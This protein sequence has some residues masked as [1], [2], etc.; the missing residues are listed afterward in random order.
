MTSV[1]DLPSLSAA[2]LHHTCDPHQFDFQTTAELEDLGELIGQMRAMEAVQFG[3]GMHHAGYNI[4]VQGPSGMGKR[5]MVRQLLARKTPT[6]PDPPEWCYLHNFKQ[7]HKPQALS[8]PP[9]RGADLRDQ[10]AKLV[11]YLRSAIP[12]LF[13]SDEYRAKAEA[14]QHAFSQREE[15]ALKALGDEAE[16]QKIFLLRTPSGFTFVPTRDGE[17]IPPDDFNKLPDDEKQRIGTAISG[18]QDKLGKILEMLP[19]WRKERAE[20][21]K[22]LNQDNTLLTVKHALDDIRTRFADVPAVLAHLDVVQQ[23]MVEH[24][25]DFKNPDETTQMGGGL[26]FVTHETFHRYQVN[27][28]V[29]QKAGSG[30]PVVTEDNPTYGNLMGRIEHLQQF[31]ALVTDFTLIQAGALHRANGGYLLLDVRKLLMQPFAWESL[32]RAMQSREIRLESLAQ[33]YSLVS[34]VSLEPEPIPLHVKV[35][36]FGDRLFYYLLQ[37]YDPDFGELFKVSADFED[38]IERNP[39]THMLYARMVATLTRKDKLLP[40]DRSAVA[41]VIDF[42]SRMVEDAHR[43]STHIRRVADLMREADY[44]ARQSGHGAVAATHVQQAMDAQIR[45]HDRV[46]SE[47]NEAILRGIILIDTQGAVQGQVNGLSVLDLG[48]FAFGQPSRITA[49]TRLGEGEVLNIEREV[50]LSGALHSKGVLILSSFLGGRYAR[51]QPLS[52]SAS[53]VFEQSYG[54]I[55]GDS[56]SLA[57]TCALLSDLAQAPIRQSLA[58]TG[59]INQLGQVQAIGGVN[60]K[61]E[62]F[63]DIC[64]ARGLTGEQGVLIPSSNVQHLMLRHDVVDAVAA[65]RFHVWAVESVDQAIALLTGVPAGE[66]DAQG[67]YPAGSVNQ[68]VMARLKALTELWEETEEAEDG[69]AGDGPHHKAKTKGSAHYEGPEDEGQ[70]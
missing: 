23:D 5:S 43:L 38:R 12:G 66:P 35:V 41:R 34:T 42:S 37:E 1:I 15:A 54:H 19:R 18:L 16:S 11:D 24:V 10:M 50:K 30:A 52:L 28:L 67:E 14:I 47:L 65:G 69:E 61:I 40:F 31:G 22:Q 39:D 9:G 55:D 58:V 26:A 60:E 2:Q 27:V 20:Q 36:L 48:D 6:E 8:L 63:F 70:A 68:R 25:D 56:A 7:P 17:V 53:L 21:L 32:K 62:G 33:M 3:T 64:A 57:E 59:S 4:Y 49:I 29:T 13:E 51:N 46:R 44:W 45:R